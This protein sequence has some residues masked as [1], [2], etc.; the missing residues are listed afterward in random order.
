MAASPR[1]GEFELIARY[2]APLAAPGAFGLLD[3]AAVIAPPAGADLVVTKDALVAGRHFFADDP[4]DTIAR[5]AL[6]VNL[7]DLAAKG[8][9]PLGFLLALALPEDWKEP[10]LARFA[11]GLAKDVRRYHV[12]LLGGDTVATTGPTTL[13]ITAF[14]A[15]PAGTMVRRSGARPGDLLY[16]TGEI[17]L[18]TLGLMD[19]L[20]R[21]PALSLPLRRRS[22]RRYLVPEPPVA[23]AAAV[24]EHATAAMDVS[25]GLIGD[26]RKLASASGAGLEIDVARVPFPAECA[27]PGRQ[28][29]TLLEA[30]LTGGDEYQ[31]LAA[32]P[33][34]RAN[35]FE[36]AAVAARIRVTAIGRMTRRGARIIGPDGR[37]LRLATGSFSHF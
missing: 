27:A 1:P 2:F 31:V 22:R 3:D 12:P 20:E 15:V 9:R 35:S 7:S 16:V 37:S 6:R 11:E 25:D 30:L 29:R 10:W 32:V 4:P 33:P 18:S 17:G 24:R 23:F 14:G 28:D 8:A 21:A 5:K 34:D 13:S 26:A 36:L 19:R